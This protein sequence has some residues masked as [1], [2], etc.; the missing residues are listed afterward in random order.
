MT[1]ECQGNCMSV[2]TKPSS[3]QCYC[4]DR[5]IGINKEGKEDFGKYRNYNIAA[6]QGCYTR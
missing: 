4:M 1:G 5:S 3:C 2:Y 6:D